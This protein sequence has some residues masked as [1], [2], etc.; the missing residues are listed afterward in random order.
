MKLDR[1]TRDDLPDLYA[2]IESAYRGNSARA[3]WSHEADLLDGQRTDRQELEAILA[4]AARHLFVLRD[5]EAIAA[6]VALT[7][8]GEG[9]VYLG[10]L[11]VDPLRQA[12]G[13]GRLLL[14]AAEDHAAADLGATRVEMTVIAQ[15]PELI[16]WY[17]RRGYLATGE[18]R[19]FPHGDPRAGRPK[20]DDLEFIVL[21]KPL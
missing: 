15:R 1:A 16:T 19:P 11:T 4:D 14:A 13:V 18:R 7:D 12:S 6:C 2:L 5:G 17:V 21:E 9:C 8:K 20:R 10:L 3:G